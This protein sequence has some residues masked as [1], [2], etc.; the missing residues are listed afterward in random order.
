MA[1]EFPGMT[2]S[3]VLMYVLDRAQESADEQ[4]YA[5]AASYMQDADTVKNELDHIAIFGTDS[6]L[7]GDENHGNKKNT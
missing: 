2:A 4:L 1:T 3:Q 7:S 6:Q 5:L